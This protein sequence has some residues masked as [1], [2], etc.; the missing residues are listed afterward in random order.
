MISRLNVKPPNPCEQNGEGVGRR[1]GPFPSEF[2]EI[3]YFPRCFT[4]VLGFLMKTMTGKVMSPCLEGG[5]QCSS[6]QALMQR[7]DGIKKKDSSSLWSKETVTSSEV[8]DSPVWKKSIRRKNLK[9]LRRA[10]PSPSAALPPCPATPPH[11]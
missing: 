2:L 5:S 10:P 3:V 7:P 9:P 6:C 4:G 11:V 8:L 1:R